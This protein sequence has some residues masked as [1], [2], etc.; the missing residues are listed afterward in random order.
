MRLWNAQTGVWQR[1]MRHEGEWG[2]ADATWHLR[3]AFA[4][5]GKTVASGA[6][7]GV[8][9]WD[10][11]TGALQR[12]LRTL[13]M[14][15]FPQMDDGSKVFGTDDVWA[16][17][18]SPDGKT[19]AVG[20]G[21]YMR[22]YAWTGRVHLWDLQ[23]GRRKRTL[24]GHLGRVWTV[25]F[26]PDGRM[27]ADGSG[28]AVGRGEVRL[29]DLQTATIQRT[30]IRDSDPAVAVVFS[31]DSKTVASLHAEV[32]N[33]TPQTP[34]SFGTSL[35]DVQ[36]GTVLLA[37]SFMEEGH[38]SAVVFSPDGKTVAI[39]SAGGMKLWDPR[40]GALQ[41][42]L[43]EGSGPWVTAV[44][45]SPDSKRVAGG[46]DDQTVRLWD[47]HTGQLHQALT[48][49]RS[50]V[51]SVAFAPDGKTVVSGS[52]D[53]QVRLWEV[54]TGMLQHTL[55]GHKG[56]VTTVAFAPDGT[57]VISAGDGTVRV[58]NVQTGALQWTL[59]GTADAFSPDG[60]T[61]AWGWGSRVRLADVQTGTVRHTL[62]GH[63]GRVTAVA[64][65]PN[66]TLLASSSVD[67][68]TK[69]WHVKSGRLL[70]T[71]M[72]LAPEDAPPSPDHSLVCTPEGYYTGS[73]GIERFLR[74]RVG[75]ALVPADALRARYHRP[76]L[77]QQAL[78]GKEVPPAGP[79]TGP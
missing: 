43:V 51:A 22:Y 26:S 74:F 60:T 47:T 71:L 5:D 8:H 30:L 64:F 33:D 29:W 61:V 23:T 45:F 79:F 13:T 46:G 3:V 54:E 40:T 18:F 27:V 72:Q 50:K 55:T 4:P 57:R 28:A 70:A 6:E 19:L 69:L 73:P 7:T 38:I 67:G 1:T 32:R 42:T 78:A 11:Q 48:G 2:S 41:R 44:A 65:A 36:T 14:E 68:T 10:P 53:G 49:H 37:L 59:T 15:G 39:S 35:W 76:S 21:D 24:R 63:S 9:L 75:Q 66:G 58:W 62:T 20:T 16:V 25:A 52:E 56:K 17:A 12:T 31:P 34:A 77:V